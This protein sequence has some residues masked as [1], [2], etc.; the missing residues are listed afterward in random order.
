MSNTNNYH[1]PSL[2]TALSEALTDCT[3]EDID[4]ALDHVREISAGYASV[5]LRDRRGDVLDALEA[6][7]TGLVARRFSL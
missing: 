6:V 4:E 5:H 3:K 7:E 2:V 1:L